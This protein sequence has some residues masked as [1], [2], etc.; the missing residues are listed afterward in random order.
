MVDFANSRFWRFIAVAL[1]VLLALD[2]GHRLLSSGAIPDPMPSAFGT[3]GIVNTL[4][5]G[6]VTTNQEGTIVYRWGKIQGTPGGLNVQ[7]FDAANLTIDRL[8]LK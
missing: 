2:V 7:R 5:D 3:G 8:D 1:V 4:E 6:I